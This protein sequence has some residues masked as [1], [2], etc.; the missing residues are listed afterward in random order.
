MRK[1]QVING[2]LYPSHIKVYIKRGDCVKQFKLSMLLLLDM[3]FI[4]AWLGG[5]AVAESQVLNGK[6]IMAFHACNTATTNCSDP[7][8]H[9]VYIA[10]SDDGSNWSSLPGYSSYS[11]SV[12]DLI[13]RGNTLYVYTPGQVRRYQIDTSTW[14]DAAPVSVSIKHGDGTSDLFV[15]PSPILD[16]NGRI[17]LFYLVGQTGGDPASCQSGQTSCTKIFRSATEVSG[18]DGVSFLVDDGNRAEITIGSP[19]NASDP[20]VFKVPDGYI[21]Y[22]A[23]DGGVQA[24]RANDF[25]GG[26]Q[27]VSS[28]PDGMLV[29]AGEGSVPS[30]YYDD[31]T[32][33]YWTYVHTPQGNTAVIKR[34]VTASIN[35]QIQDSSFTTVISGSAFPGLG[36]TYKVESPG[37]ALNTT[38]ICAATISNDL[39]MHIP[40]LAYSSLYFWADFQYV[41]N[42]L[43]FLLTNFGEIT[44]PGNFS[45]C[46][47]STIS[48]DLVLHV[49]AVFYNSVSY[50]ADFQYAN[51]MVFTLTNAVVN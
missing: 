33:Q 13:R 49:P 3:I 11:G 45:S 39:K 25:R 16:D 28:L 42:T 19:G 8:N 14:K 43:D 29:A 36:S 21:M 24:L 22:I 30:G 40:V 47:P 23:R 51:E 35:T 2:N 4:G 12:P 1:N 6:Y 37:F 34:A 32:G 9:K 27:D 20:D 48:A 5:A 10:Q 38:N 26:Y 15:D 41:T 17:V 18:S 50:R 31:T 46:S 44:E 7:R